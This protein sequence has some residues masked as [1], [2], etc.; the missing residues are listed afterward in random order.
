M[1][2]GPPVDGPKDFHIESITDFFALKTQEVSPSAFCQLRKN[3]ISSTTSP[4]SWSSACSGVD[5]M[6]QWLPNIARSMSKYDKDSNLDY[7]RLV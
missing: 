3:L 2:S 6:Q 1:V 7:G 5:T 4:I